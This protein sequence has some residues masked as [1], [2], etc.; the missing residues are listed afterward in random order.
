MAAGEF[1]QFPVESRRQGG[2]AV[3]VEDGPRCGASGRRDDVRAGVPQRGDVERVLDHRRE[4]VPDE[5]V[6]VGLAQGVHR[7]GCE[8]GFGVPVRG[9]DAQGPGD[10]RERRAEALAEVEVLDRGQFV[11]VAGPFGA[12]QEARCDG[13]VGDEDA[14]PTPPP[15]TPADGSPGAARPA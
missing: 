6:E 2:R 3:V 9:V 15:R 1:L 5:E 12:G 4:V 13:F 7:L 14:D 11:L 8:V 10:L